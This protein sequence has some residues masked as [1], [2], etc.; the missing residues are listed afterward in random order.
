MPFGRSARI[1]PKQAYIYFIYRERQPVPK[2]DEGPVSENPTF[3]ALGESRQSPRGRFRHFKGVCGRAAL[4]A[5][6][7][8]A[9]GPNLW[10]FY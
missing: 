9:G 2:S 7:S 4:G 8:R 6:E 5:G 10:S 3:R 1:H